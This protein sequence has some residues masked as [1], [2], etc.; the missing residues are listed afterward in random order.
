MMERGPLSDE[1]IGVLHDLTL[2]G[3]NVEV[4]TE[5]FNWGKPA[6]APSPLARLAGAAPVQNTADEPAP[7]PRRVQADRITQAEP[8]PPAPRREAPVVQAAVSVTPDSAPGGVVV[9]CNAIPT[10]AELTLLG[11]MLKAVGLETAPRALVVGNAGVA[12][13]IASQ[14]PT[15]V[16]VLGQAPLSALLGK[17]QGVEEWQR[18]PVKLLAAFGGPVGV[19]YPL[20]LL[21]KNPLYKKRTWQH[22]LKWVQ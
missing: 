19:T 15:H 13:V 6:P 16:L 10:P 20:E 5:P 11:N 7:R 17:T 18:A 4:G 14:T 9:A 22:L 21:L 2:G 12:E 8:L 1:L 3:V